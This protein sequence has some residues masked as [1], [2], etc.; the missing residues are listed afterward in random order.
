VGP[1][2]VQALVEGVARALERLEA[3]RAGH[4]GDLT[5]ALG[6]EER[7]RAERRHVL[8]AVDQGEP[9][10]GLERDWR[11]ARTPH[12]LGARHEGPLADPR[13]PFP[14]HRKRQMRER[15][16]IPRRADGALRRDARVHARVEHRDEHVN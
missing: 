7:E 9:L 5:Q 13:L 2:G 4:V 6:V 11:N 16:Q 12:R 8:R 1:C 15:G 10:L 3:H 14:D